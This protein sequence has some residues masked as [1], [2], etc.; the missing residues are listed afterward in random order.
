MSPL[1]PV[2]GTQIADFAL[3]ETDAV[4][5]SAAAVAVPNFDAGGGEGER[6]CAAGD[7]PEE[8]GDDG[9]QENAFGC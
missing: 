4:E 6:G 8:F 9:A 1:E 2:D 3:G 5:V 7:E